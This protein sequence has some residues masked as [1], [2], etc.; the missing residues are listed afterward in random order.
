[1]LELV[2]SCYYVGPRDQTPVV[3]FDGKRLYSLSFF[4]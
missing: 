2:L 4:A 3:S 1:M